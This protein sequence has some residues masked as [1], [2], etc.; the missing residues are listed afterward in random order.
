MMAEESGAVVRQ[1]GPVGKKAKHVVKKRKS[2]AKKK[3]F[4]K[5]KRPVVKKRHAARKKAALCQCPQPQTHK[6]AAVKVVP[7]P[8]KKAPEASPPE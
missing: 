8:V 4:V 3:S 5:K 7:K 1:H 2:S 6:K